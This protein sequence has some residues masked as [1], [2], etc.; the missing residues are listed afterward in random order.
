MQESAYKV[1]QGPKARWVQEAAPELRAVQARIAVLLRRVTPP[2]YRHS[3][4][5]GRSFL[6]NASAHQADDPSIKID[7]KSFYPSV[8][9]NQVR[10]FF[11]KDMKCSGDVAYL[12]ASIS[13]YKQRHLPTGGVHSEVLAFY[14]FKGCLDKLKRRAEARGGV[15]TVYVDDIMVTMPEASDGDL[16]WAK[17]LLSE[18]GMILNRTKSRIIPK[19]RAKVITGVL[20]HRGRLAAPPKQHLAI[21]DGFANLRDLKSTNT[22]ASSAA[23][24]L[25]GHLD[26]VAQIDPRFRS[27]ATGNR[28]RLQRTLADPASIRKEE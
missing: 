12:L 15:M 5:R 9:F 8:T 18:H 13:C 26:H 11:K 1:W 7:I 21:R 22:E 10:N 20:I 17:R 23:R 19:G 28:H 6:T 4:V 14:C 24:S 16:R 3:G 2:D 25:L 27:R